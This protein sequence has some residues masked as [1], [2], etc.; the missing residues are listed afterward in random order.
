MLEE[1]WKPGAGPQGGTCLPP[2]CFLSL[3]SLAHVLITF[4]LLDQNWSP[5]VEYK[6]W[7]GRDHI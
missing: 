4:G 2:K 5:L 3:A 6:L 7:E 1:Y